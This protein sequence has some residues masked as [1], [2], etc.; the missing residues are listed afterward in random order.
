MLS[1]PPD[2]SEGLGEVSR[3]CLV[4]DS[5]NSISS[6]ADEVGEGVPGGDDPGVEGSYSEVMDESGS[7]KWRSPRG[8]DWARIGVDGK[9]ILDV[10]GSCVTGVCMLEMSR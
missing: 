9:L 4:K 2:R 5:S 8:I 3:C 10:V 7:D 6:S 1:D